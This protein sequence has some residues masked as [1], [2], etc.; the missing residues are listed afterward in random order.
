MG[1]MILKKKKKKRKIKYFVLI[2]IIYMSFSYSFYYMI[3]DN[4]TVS[5]EDFINILVSS[6]NANILSKYRTTNIVNGT[7][8]FFLN[9]DFTD[10]VSL[11]N[12]SILKN[13]Y[14]EK[15]RKI[16][17]TIAISYN[18]DYSDMDDLKKVSDYIRDPNPKT[19]DKPIIYLYNS[20]QLENYSNDN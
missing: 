13:G 10:P 6:G 4:K 11:F 5:N 14:K 20:H 16:E 7:M 2:I 3:K 15:K 8:K 1:K 19:A 12:T 9:I 18:D 17:K